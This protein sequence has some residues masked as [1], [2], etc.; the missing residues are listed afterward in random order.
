MLCDM[1]MLI[2]S[3]SNIVKINLWWICNIMTHCVNINKNSFSKDSLRVNNALKWLR[4]CQ[5]H[6]HF[7]CIK[8]QNQP[9]CCFC[10]EMLSNLNHF[11]LPWYSAFNDSFIHYL[12]VLHAFLNSQC[13]TFCHLFKRKIAI[14]VLS[15]AWVLL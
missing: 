8:M 12:F 5:F 11:C 2:F 4:C 13:L 6:L 1:A 15:E 3:V 9:P 10:W 14:V 7:Y